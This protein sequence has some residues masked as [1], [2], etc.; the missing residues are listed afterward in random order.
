MRI[1]ALKKSE[2]G[3]SLALRMVEMEGID[4]QVELKFY[5]PLKSLFKTNMIEEEP[6]DTGMKGK[7]LKID[8]GKNAIETFRM[9]LL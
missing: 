8:I 9:D 1:T 4:K 6:K 5:F 2:S 3:N 7:V